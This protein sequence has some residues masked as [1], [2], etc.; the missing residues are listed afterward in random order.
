MGQSKA[1]VAHQHGTELGLIHNVNCFSNKALT[2]LRLLP[3]LIASPS[4]STSFFKD[5][6]SGSH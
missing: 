3:I 4:L 2:K 1:G 6:V 5:A